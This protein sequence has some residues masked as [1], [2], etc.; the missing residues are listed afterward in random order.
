METFSSLASLDQIRRSPLSPMLRE[1][2]VRMLDH[3]ENR[4]EDD[5]FVLCA[6]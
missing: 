5:G 2:D 3:F 6:V 4:P 1:I